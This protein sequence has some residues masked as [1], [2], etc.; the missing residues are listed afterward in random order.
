MITARP[1][2][3]W[4]VPKEDLPEV[5]AAYVRGVKVGLERSLYALPTLR[6]VVPEHMLGPFREGY[7]AGILDKNCAIRALLYPDDE[8][9]AAKWERV[10]NSQDDQL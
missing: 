6:R 9:A 10:Y 2:G 7:K 5:H 8:S 1:G 4:N 3:G